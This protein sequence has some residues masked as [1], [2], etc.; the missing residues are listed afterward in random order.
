MARHLLVTNDF[1]PKTGG[2]QSYLFELWRRLEPGRAA[3]L[4]A[5]SHPGAAEF[6][7][8][9]GLEID[10]V[11]ASTLFMPTPGALRAVRAAIERHHVELVLFDPAWPLGLLGPFLPV[12]YG[13]IVHGAEVTIPGHL[14]GA[15]ATLRR[16]LAGASV[17]LAAGH[18]P[19]AQTRRVAAERHPPTIQA[20]PGVDVTRFRPLDQGAKDRVRRELGISAQE[21]AIATYSRLVPRKGFDTLIRASAR[22]APRYPQLRVYAGGSGRDAKRL[23]SLARRLKAPVHFLGRVNDELLPAWLGASDL[24]VMDCRSRWMGLEREGFGIVFLE[25]QAAGVAAVAG[26]SGGSHEA[27]AHGETGIVLANPHSV[28]ALSE[29]IARLIDDDQTRS[30]LATRARSFVAERFSWEDVATRL[31]RDLAPYDHFESAPRGLR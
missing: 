2:I 4:T 25:A 3:I 22:L 13:V 18:Y 14:P 20:P 31:S 21:F 17:V 8:D 1:P 29:A 24:F 26:R 23:E 10:R 12:P 6:D 7:R 30:R 9:S 16:V 27:V 11:A 28:R 5:S 15:A 19:E